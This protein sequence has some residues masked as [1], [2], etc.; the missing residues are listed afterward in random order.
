MPKDTFPQ[1]AP[2]IRSRLLRSRFLTWLANLPPVAKLIEILFRIL[3]KHQLDHT[4][5]IYETE[6]ARVAAIG[7]EATLQGIVK[8]MVEALGYVGSMV[9]VYEAGDALPVRA[10][11]VDPNVANLKQIHQWED[12]ITKIAG[13]TASITN[14]DIARV[15]VHQ[16][17]YKDNLSVKSVQARKPVIS[18]E[19]YDLFTP[20]APLATKPAVNGIQRALNI[21]QVISAPFF[22]KASSGDESNQELVGNI[23][24]AKHDIISK[25]DIRILSAFGRQ[26]AAAI[27]SER[28]RLQIEAA[29]TL[30]FSMQVSMRDEEYILERIAKGIVSDLGYAGV[31]VATYEL[32]GSLPV[33]ALY[34]DPDIATVEQIRQW[35]KK[36][37]GIAGQP[38]SI[39][40]PDIARVFVHQDEY[41]DNL[42]VRA[43]QAGEPVVDDEL[44][45]L[46]TPVVPFAAKPAVK[47]IQ[48]ALGIQKVIAVPFF[49]E[50]RRDGESRRELVGNLFSFTLSKSFTNGEIELLEAFA[51]QAAAGIRNARLYRI[52]EERRQAAQIFGTMAF[53]AA[54][55]V[56][57]LRNHIG[58]F[59]GHFELLG[60]KDL[61]PD[62]REQLLTSNPRIRSRLDEA[63]EILDKLHEPWRQA[64]D[65][66]LVDVTFCLNR[67][68]NKIIPDQKTIQVS[69]D[70][71]IQSELA[72]DLPP[73]KTSPDMFTEAFRVLLKNAL[74]AIQETGRG[75]KLEIRSRLVDDLSIEILISDTGIGIRPENV[76]KIFEM[77]WTSKKEGMGFGLF[78]TRDYIEGIG[79]SIKVESEWQRGTT[80]RV[81]LPIEQTDV[82]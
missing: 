19:L 13:E 57:T 5:A 2:G 76:S 51:Q 11:Y 1:Q 66:Q 70:I 82:P 9:A 80:F 64:D 33:R 7:L 55:S 16:E 18:D 29:Q 15:F 14:P 39:T 58:A 78:W 67:A 24:A 23:I 10:L 68:I 69:E 31:M 71:S 48:Q 44:F 40:D 20:V 35:E 54:A 12:Q 36:I 4:T 47:G 26:A 17:K 38:M 42:S 49:L 65:N 30:V 73:I 63:A 72:D 50:T 45:S 37:T 74:E 6:T 53:S 75:G 32:D 77:R 25:Q 52:A 28:R 22:L 41:K 46:F 8:D 27:E 3:S 79:G 62:L 61:T 34:V 21:K 43:A 56:H 81:R 59:R 60:M